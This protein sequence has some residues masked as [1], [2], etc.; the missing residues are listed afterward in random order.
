[1]KY[2]SSQSRRLNLIIPLFAF[3]ISACGG[4]GTTSAVST[5]PVSSNPGGPASDGVY[6]PAPLAWE[7]MNK[8]GILWS[9][10]SYQIIGNDAAPALL[11]GANDMPDFCPN[12]ASLSDPEK[13]NFWAYL[14]STIAKFESGFVVTKR[15]HEATRGN[16]ELTKLPVYSEGL[17]QLSYQDGLHYAFCAFDWLED[18]KLSATNPKKSILDPF[19][20]LECGIKIL[21]D[22]VKN[23]NTI[24]SANAYWNSLKAGGS[25][26]KLKDI[27][28]ATSA[29]PF[30]VRP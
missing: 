19:R 27:A 21:A 18:Q 15:A 16:D 2:M 1:M 6:K 3:A 23:K 11:P 22:Q 30:C 29:L 12:Y 17:L 5:K 4:K 13:V 25:K 14:V 10:F 28:A 8:D 9:A 24:A 20:N 26:S 7:G